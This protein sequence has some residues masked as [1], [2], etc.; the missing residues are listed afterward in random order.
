MEGSH[1]KQKS[2]Q[3]LQQLC[4]FPPFY[5]KKNM[6]RI[7]Q[8]PLKIVYALKFENQER[9]WC[10]FQLSFDLIRSVHHNL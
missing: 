7:N 1:Q 4:Q 2:N 3:R 10:R 5:K 8:A 6:S 9:P